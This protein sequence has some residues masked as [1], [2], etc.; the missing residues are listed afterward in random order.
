MWM[1]GV[2]FYAVII[3]FSI[4][5]KE[6]S[7]ATLSFD[8]VRRM[9]RVFVVIYASIKYYPISKKRFVK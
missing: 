1:F 9:C 5:L 7:T 3:F 4:M 8:Y 6:I 2:Y